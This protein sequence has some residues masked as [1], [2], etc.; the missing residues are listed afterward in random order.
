MESRPSTK[1]LSFIMM[2]ANS[3]T[4]EEELLLNNSSES[5]NSSWNRNS[6]SYGEWEEEDYVGSFHFSLT[7]QVIVYVLYNAVFVSAVLG[8]VLVVYVIGSTARLRTV[9][10]YLIGKHDGALSNTLRAF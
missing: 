10:N 9:T 7:F 2:T 3:S 1:T 6:S 5:G 8:N 4:E